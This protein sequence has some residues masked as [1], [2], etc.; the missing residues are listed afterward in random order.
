M[1]AGNISTYD[2]FKRLHEIRRLIE[3][4]KTD[5]DIAKEIG[6]S[7]SAVQRN[8]QYLKD[9]AIADLT[10]EEVGEKRAELYLEL[11]EAST[12]A[13]KLFEETKEKKPKSANT[14][15]LRWLDTIKLRITLYGLDSVKVGSLVQVNNLTQFKEPERISSELADKIS[16]EIKEVHSRRLKDEYNAV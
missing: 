6:M 7:L 1:P 13:Q 9:L 5:N 11:L 4:G 12:E 15:M 2:R 16:K 8:K 14:W 10:S 3:E